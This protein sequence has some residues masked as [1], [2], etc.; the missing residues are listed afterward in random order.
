MFNK[1]NIPLQSKTMKITE[2]QYK[3]IQALIISSLE[4]EISDLN[5]TAKA[6]T[7]MTPHIDRYKVSDSLNAKKQ[8]LHKVKYSGFLHYPNDPGVMTQIEEVAK[9]KELSTVE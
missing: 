9:R 4:K 5:E 2:D 1:A 8:H 7:W 3:E 6:Q